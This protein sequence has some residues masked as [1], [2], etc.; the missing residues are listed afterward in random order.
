MEVF[1]LCAWLI[2]IG[3]LPMVTNDR[4]PLTF[5]SLLFLLG[6]AFI[7]SRFLLKRKWPMSW[8]QITIMGCGLV[9]IFL[10]LRVEYAAG[11]SL[12]SGQWFATYGNQ[13]ISFFTKY[14]PF[15]FAI[16]AALYCWWR[17]ISLSHSRLYFDDIYH[18]FLIQLTA[19]VFLIIMWSFTYKSGPLKNITSNIGIYVVGF[20]FF[21]LLALALTNLRVIQEKFRKKGELSKNFGRR[22]LTTI[23]IVIGG[24]I[25][26]GIGFASIFSSQFVSLLGKFMN[27]ISG[28]YSAVINFILEAIGL[29]VQLMYDIGEFL[30]NLIPK[31]KAPTTTPETSPLVATTTTPGSGGVYYNPQLVLIV[32]LVFLALLVFG[33]VFLISRAIQRQHRKELTEDVEEEQESLWSWEGFKADLMV[34][35]K[36]IFQLFKRKKKP[37]QANITTDWQVED[38][39]ERRLNIREI[40]QHLLWHGSLLKIPREKYETPSEYARRLGQVVPDGKEPLDEITGFYIDARYGDHPVEEKKTDRANS[41]WEKL[42]SLFKGRE[43]G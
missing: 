5:W 37:A 26:L 12:F 28:A 18:S 9:A 15:V 19:L 35:F 21:G 1:S 25:L 2:F 31:P 8:I 29:L 39:I 4:P 3:N 38:D 33:A 10:V 17:G 24:V 23:L 34:F 36:A 43:T 41:L 7:A 20:F 22:W 6:G 16:I 13:I 42:R 30:I 27:S 11:F 14:P 32:K 40:Y